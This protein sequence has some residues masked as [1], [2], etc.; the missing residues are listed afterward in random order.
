MKKL[1]GA[2]Y[3]YVK[4]EFNGWQVFYVDRDKLNSLT[5]GIRVE[6][7]LYPGLNRKQITIKLSNGNTRY[8]LEVRNVSGGIYPNTITLKFRK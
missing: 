3:F 2:N 1:V 8:Y 6:E 5:N 4:K 7:V